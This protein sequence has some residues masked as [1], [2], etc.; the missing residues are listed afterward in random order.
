MI[1]TDRESH[2]ITDH[3]RCPVYQWWLIFGLCII[4]SFWIYRRL[5]EILP[6]RSKIWKDSPSIATEKGAKLIEEIHKQQEVMLLYRMIHLC[7]SIMWCIKRHSHCAIYPY[8]SKTRS[9]SQ[10]HNCQKSSSFQYL[11]INLIVDFLP[12]IH[13]LDRYLVR[14]QV[15]DWIFVC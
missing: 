14:Q 8:G 2:L 1:T 12:S 7:D 13:F 10:L 9:S 11:L 3:F 4:V 5:Q 6:E 15:N